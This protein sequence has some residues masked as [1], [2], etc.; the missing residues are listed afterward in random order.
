MTCQC[1]NLQY[2][3]PESITRI[4]TSNLSFTCQSLRGRS[5]VSSVRASCREC[6]LQPHVS[7]G[8][9]FLALAQSAPAGKLRLIVTRRSSSSYLLVRQPPMCPLKEMLLLSGLALFALC[10]SEMTWYIESDTTPTRHALQKV[11]EHQIR[12][13]SDLASNTTAHNRAMPQPNA[14]TP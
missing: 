4:F 14:N 11:I 12:M 10:C 5:F 1:C 9:G 2:E 13:I 6:I 8:A 3:S 7:F